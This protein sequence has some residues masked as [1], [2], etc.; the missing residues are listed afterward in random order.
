MLYSKGSIPGSNRLIFF[1]IP[2]LLP[3]I[4]L[5]LL[6]FVRLQPGHAGA[7]QTINLSGSELSATAIRLEWRISNPGAIRSISVYRSATGGAGSFAAIANLPATNTSYVDRTV[8]RGVTYY[9]QVKSISQFNLTSAPSNTMMIATTGSQGETPPTPDTGSSDQ[10]AGGSGQSAQPAESPT[11]G[12]FVAPNGQPTNDGSKE[13]PID[14]LTA[15]SSRSPVRPGMTIW[16]RGGVYRHPGAKLT[17]TEEPAL[18]SVLTGNSSSPI[19]VRQYPGER[20]TIDGGLRVEGAWTIYRDFEITN[21]STDRTQKRPMGLHVFG[22]HTKF[23]NLVIHDSG[24]GI[25]FWLPAEDS[26]IY[27]AIIYRNGWEATDDYRGH[28]HGIYVQNQNGSKL[29]SDVISFDNYSSG[30]KAYTESGY[31]NGITFEGNISFNNGSTAQPQRDYDRVENMLVG[32]SINPPERVALNNNYTYHPPATKGTSVFLG[33]TTD[34]NRDIQLKDNYFVGGSRNHTYM[35]RWA[36]VTMTGNTFIGGTDLIVL[37]MP[38]GLR[39]TT[40][41][42]WDNNSYFSRTNQ[43]PF[44]YTDDA[45]K[46][47]YRNLADWQ[48]TTGLDRNS[49]WLPNANNRPIGNKIFIRPNKYESGRANIA[50]YN[51]ELKDKVEV[52]ISAILKRGDRFEVRNAQ[53]FFG[54]PVLTGTYA[55]QAL[56]LPMTGT[57]TGPEF[58]AFVLITL[59]SSSNQQ[60]TTPTTT[61]TPRPTPT[62]TP[63]PTPTNPTTNSTAATP[64][65][66][67]E[68]KLLGLINDYRLQ[69]GRNPLGPSISLTRASDWMAQDMSRLNYVNRIDSQG[70]TPAQRARAFGFPGSR[71]LLEENAMVASGDL[72][73]Q[74][75]FD[76]WKSS[77]PDNEVLLNVNW[78][79]AGI[80]RSFSATSNRWNWSVTFGAYWDKTIEIAGE[81]DEGR[82]DNN[83]L[84]RTRP[85]SAALAAN[86]NFS[87]YGDNGQAYDPVHCDLN[88]NP[89]ICWHDPPPQGNPRLAETSAIENLPASWKL[90]YRI[91]DAGVVHANYD[92]WDSTGFEIELE[93]NPNGTWTMRGYRAFQDSVPIETGSWRA[94]PSTGRNETIVTFNRQPGLP[95]TTIRVHAARGQL[96]LFAID[97]G[98]M[99]RNFLRGLAADDNS[100][101][102]P[103]FIFL[104]KK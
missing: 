29:I 8:R 86:H 66:P 7:D 10:A 48:R 38:A 17:G 67:E 104:L 2:A 34:R 100:K 75:L 60:N 31:I 30:M 6:V 89:R 73:A 28:G 74:Q 15:I 19:T 71:A 21:S 88:S 72:N 14:L 69:N 98:V 94:S 58:N 57:P 68:E 36:Q 22:H 27:G 23:I 4:S 79:D 5:I 96:T 16:L 45:I 63:P 49:K 3:A 53:N 82:I 33:Y 93:I 55:G 52:D 25:G 65:D 40:Y 61:P 76:L 54:A 101:D 59:S 1:R 64:L 18:I 26:E 87:G 51:W 62:P 9:Y 92:E 91:S 42:Q 97:G 35:T 78:K 80:G 81:D 32:S 13:R 43:Y 84:I 77:L 11:S 24:N 12:V 44:I 102:D 85:P 50:I 95:Q 47:G 37:Q 70:R 46:G 103:Q 99:M 90:A 41:Q 56:S 83:D 39:S 20:A